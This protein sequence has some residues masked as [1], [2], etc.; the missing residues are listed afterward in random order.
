MSHLMMYWITRLDGLSILAVTALVFVGFIIIVGFMMFTMGDLDLTE[1]KT[2]VKILSVVAGVSLFILLF[3][4]SSKEVAAIW[5]IP[6]IVNNEH[7]QKIPDN[8][9]I[10]LN[11]KLEEWLKV[12][13]KEKK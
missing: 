6:K 3:V 4:P 12:D 1:H 10:L 2:G 11:K 9:A 13:E 5:L 8:A 7:I